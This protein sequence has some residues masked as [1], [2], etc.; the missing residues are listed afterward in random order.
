IGFLQVNTEYPIPLYKNLNDN[1][2]FDTIKFTIDNKGITKFI[3]KLDLKPFAIYEGDSY[4]AGE[5]NISMGL[6]RFPPELK[7]RVIDSTKTTFTVI[8][9]EKSSTAFIIKR[10]A[11]SVYYKTEREYY[12]NNCIG[13]PNSVYNSKWYI[14]ETWERYLKRVESTS[15]NNL[16]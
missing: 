6:I 13:C 16:K 10:D 14:F 12:D 9:N 4:Q 5:K 2:P 11:Q 7:L 15:K 8:T 3:T 1:I